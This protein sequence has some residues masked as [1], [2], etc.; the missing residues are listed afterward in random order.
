MAG[1]SKTHWNN[2]KEWLLPSETFAQ[3]ET[4][5]KDLLFG[6]IAVAAFYAILT[7]FFIY[8]VGRLCY[9]GR[10]ELFSN[11][12]KVD[13][14][15]APS[16]AF[17]PFNPNDTIQWPAGAEPW[18]TANKVEMYGEN[19]LDVVARNCTFDRNCA[20]I[21]MS[22]FHLRDVT[23]DTAHEHKE[24]GKHD[25]V[26]RE[27]IDIRTN[28]SDPSAEQVLKIGIY[29]SI[30]DRPDWFYVNQGSMFVGQLEMTVWTIVDVSIHG[31]INT[32]K[33]DL[34]AMVKNRH[35]YRYTSQQ[36]GSLREHPPWQETSIRYE[37]KTFFVEETMSSP[38]AF[39]WY[40]VGVIFLLFAARWLILD[41]F[42]AVTM[43]E[44]KE[45]ST[46]TVTRELTSHAVWLRDL[47]F[48]CM[49]D[50]EPSE[51]EPL[52]EGKVDA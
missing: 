15:E 7:G 35:I 1:V 33:G 6:R 45:T 38:S 36:V 44:W 25:F 23:E 14:V 2:F 29:D 20:C 40:T 8:T 18:A 17:C 5:K 46:G 51:R 27:S 19:Q 32:F 21:D 41:A 31:L 47:C 30:D 24:R 9:S 11:L 52:I 12:Y 49:R 3:S 43:P 16:L 48:C 4:P 10:I 28:L 34:R 22:A 37:M 26:F 13:Y 39:S 50:S 42:Y